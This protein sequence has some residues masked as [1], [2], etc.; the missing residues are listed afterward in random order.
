MRFNTRYK[1]SKPSTFLDLSARQQWKKI[2]P[3]TTTPHLI[4]HSYSAETLAFST[5]PA[6]TNMTGRN[7]KSEKNLKTFPNV[8]ADGQTLPSFDEQALSAL[9]DKIEKDLGKA[10]GKALNSTA[11]IRGT[12]RVPKISTS[13]ESKSQRK[14]K[15]H[16]R[17]WKRD[18]R[19]NEKTVS[20]RSA[21]DHGRLRNNQ[22]GEDVDERKVLL[23]EILALGGTEEDL[24]LVGDAAS[25]DEEED[26]RDDNALPS[27]KSFR[28][29]LA[30]FVADLGIDGKVGRDAS[31]SEDEE[32]VK[33]TWED[34]SDFTHH[35]ASGD[36]SQLEYTRK[37]P[38]AHDLKMSNISLKDQNRLVSTSRC[39]S[40]L[41]D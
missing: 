8:R 39:A 7:N 6:T 28:E 15:G 35:N 5:L 37:T 12:Q 11:S 4:G 40:Q 16:D 32:Y 13:A 2:N 23:R 27:D 17:G 30:K 18:A 26:I 38:A 29:D 34:A 25:H 3:E 21:K 33:D 41:S 20:Q 10:S 36:T 31:E 9:T 14:T 22:A 19:G 1:L 24:D